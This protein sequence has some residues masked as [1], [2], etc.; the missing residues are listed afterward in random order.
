M[1][2]DDS[3]VRTLLIVIAAIL[4]LPFLMMALLMPLMG[5]WGWS[6]MP[7][8]AM[9]GGAGSTWMWLVM[10]V[11]PL[12][13]ILGVGYVLFNTVRSSKTDETDPA[14]EQLRATY[15]R[16]ELSDEEFEK[17]RERLERE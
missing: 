5:L 10:S 2:D 14:L 4:L 3:L 9:W 1:A 12:L 16:G 11:V 13:V 15:A 8:G 6:H 17:R 7:N